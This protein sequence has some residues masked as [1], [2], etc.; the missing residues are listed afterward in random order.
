MTNYQKSVKW[1]EFI[2]NLG[3]EVLKILLKKYI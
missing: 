1:C 2:N 3:L